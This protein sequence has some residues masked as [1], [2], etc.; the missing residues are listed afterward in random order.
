MY[1][2]VLI[3]RH[4]Q[5]D[6]WIVKRLRQKKT[7]DWVSPDNNAYIM[8]IERGETIDELQERVYCDIRDEILDLAKI[9]KNKFY[10]HVNA[11][12][13]TIM[14]DDNNLTVQAIRIG[15][16]SRKPRV[17][18]KTIPLSVYNTGFIYLVYTCNH[19]MY[20]AQYEEAIRYGMKHC[21][22]HN[23]IIYLI[24]TE[25][26]GGP[27]FD[28]AQNR[29]LEEDRYNAECSERI[30]D[31][32]D[33]DDIHKIIM[34]YTAYEFQRFSPDGTFIKGY[35]SNCVDATQYTFKDPD[36]INALKYT[37]YPISMDIN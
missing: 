37:K 10:R 33:P 17:M 23:F 9:N 18:V 29:F 24:R 19:A 12:T 14:I 35:R 26:I 15:N 11:I 25:H 5:F 13:Q 30:K 3:L 8:Q 6:D 28:F 16:G 34:E 4:C 20:A 32:T 21:E 36:F 27:D 22:G 2:L 1:K 31:L 7:Y